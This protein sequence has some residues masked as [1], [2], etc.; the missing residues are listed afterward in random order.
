LQVACGYFFT[1]TFQNAFIRSKGAR[2]CQA[3]HALLKT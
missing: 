3:K 1:V 2:I